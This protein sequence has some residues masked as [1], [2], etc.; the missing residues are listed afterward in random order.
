MIF[1]QKQLNHIHNQIHIA[2]HNVNRNPQNIQLIAV[3][4]NQSINTIKKSIFYG[5]RNFGENYVQEALKKICWFRT[6]IPDKISWHFI[7]SIQSNKI[8]I[9][10]ENFD[11]CHTISNEK[12]IY[13]L[14]KHRPKKLSQLN[15]LI[16]I[17]ISGNHNKS[18]IITIEQML[19]L[20]TTIYQCSKLKLRGI[21]SM[22][23]PKSEFKQQ[24]IQFKK[25]YTFFKR[26]Q[27]ICP[28]VDTLSLGMS[29][30]IL[31]A[32]YSGSNLLRIGTSIFETKSNKH[33]NT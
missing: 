31:P 2:A 27:N 33:D 17:N 10:A 30:D 13:H 25:V 11:W 26:L 7:G 21:M 14:N 19:K 5:Q 22:S 1:I 32:I 9:I 29:N 4:K 3:T 6:H 23:I 24:M 12:S 16:Q 28:H 20:A 18:G 8:R 15:T